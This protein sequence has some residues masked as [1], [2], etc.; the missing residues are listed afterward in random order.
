MS[1]NAPPITELLDAAERTAVHL[2]MR[3]VYAVSMENPH[4]AAWQRTGTRP[5]DPES[6]YWRDWVTVVRRTVAR[7]V[8]VRRARVISEPPS[9]YIRYEHAGTAV[10]VAAGEEVRWLSRRRASD[11]ALP[12]NDFWLLD[13]RLVRFGYFS[14]DGAVIAHELVDEPAVVELCATAFAAVWSRAVPHESHRFS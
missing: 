7:G 13:G 9:E 1:S 12:G 2:E 3:D 4:F 14:G 5:T 10:N 6:E 11:I 8:A